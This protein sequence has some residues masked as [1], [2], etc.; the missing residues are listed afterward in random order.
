M[1][2]L[3]IRLISQLTAINSLD[4]AKYII[5]VQDPDLNS[6][7]RITINGMLLTE[8]TARLV[9]ELKIISNAGLDTAPATLGN[10]PSLAAMDYI[11]AATSILNAC[12]LLD[13][14]LKATNDAAVIYTSVN[15]THDEM[16]NCFSQNKILINAAPSGYYT[17]IIHAN[18]RY[19]PGNP[20]SQL[21]TVVGSKF[22][23]W[24]GT[25][26]YS[27]QASLVIVDYPFNLLEPL[28]M[29]EGAQYYPS[30]VVLSITE[31][32]LT[33]GGVNDLLRVDLAYKILPY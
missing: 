24:E 33:G 15:L 20:T 29:I 12:E 21:T 11:S 4:P 9:Q 31:G 6:T 30:P 25:P 19:L 2:E 16:L 10:L 14:A 28:L 7:R 1:S 13:I 32:N 8:V 17:Q 5:E 27:C 26:I 3:V 22:V 18:M 23:I